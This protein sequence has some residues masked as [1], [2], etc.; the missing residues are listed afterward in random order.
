MRAAGV[1]GLP[2]H[3]R[4]ML[5][6]A[7]L[8]HDL[9]RLGVSNAV[10]DKR[11]ALTLGERE[12]YACTRTSPGGCSPPRRRWRN[13]PRSPASTTSGWTDPGIRG[14]SPAS[15]C[16]RPRE[17]W[18]SP[19]PTSTFFQALG[20]LSGVTLVPDAVNLDGRPALALARVQGGWLR[21]EILL[22]PRTYRLIGSVRWRSP[23]TP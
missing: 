10:W 12:R 16:H 19:T 9:G 1:A 5:R 21:E 13:W 22:D 17:S 7:A 11:A 3:D 18:P 6:R 14:G 15:A 2:N 23:T 8:V 20:R 4:T